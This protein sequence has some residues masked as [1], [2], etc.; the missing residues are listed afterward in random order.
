[1]GNFYEV[2]FLLIKYLKEYFYR[3]RIKV[4][5]H[6]FNRIGEGKIISYI[7]KVLV[8]EAAKNSPPPPSGKGLGH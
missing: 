4:K 5:G 7:L 3:L 2:F 8:R 1:M 6:P